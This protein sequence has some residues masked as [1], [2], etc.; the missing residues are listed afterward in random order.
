M[1][2][3]QAAVTSSTTA[4]VGEMQRKCEVGK[5]GSLSLQSRRTGSPNC[6]RVLLLLYTQRFLF[7]F[8]QYAVTLCSRAVSPSVPLSFY[9]YF[10]YARVLLGVLFE[11]NVVCV[12]SL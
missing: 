8:G 12:A 1:Y 11:R 3:V 4:E 9:L 10:P 5:S 6:V 2:K 7:R